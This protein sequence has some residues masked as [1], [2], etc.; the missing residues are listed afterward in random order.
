MGFV[1]PV[2]PWQSLTLNDCISYDMTGFRPEEGN[3]THIYASHNSTDTLIAIVKCWHSTL[4]R[5]T[6]RFSYTTIQSG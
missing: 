5:A 4:I 6:L 1:F 2:D 3:Y